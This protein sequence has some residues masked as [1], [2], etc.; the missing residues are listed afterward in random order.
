MINEEMKEF[1]SLRIYD[2]L[3]KL[4]NQMSKNNTTEE[5]VEIQAINGFTNKTNTLKITLKENQD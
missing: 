1:L 4:G 3:N 5:Y 2:V